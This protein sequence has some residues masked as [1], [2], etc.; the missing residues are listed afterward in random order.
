MSYEAKWSQEE[1]TWPVDHTRGPRIEYGHLGSSLYAPAL[2]SAK[3][4]WKYPRSIGTDDGSFKVCGHRRAVRSGSRLPS[5]LDHTTKF[6]VNRVRAQLAKVAPDSYIPTGVLSALSK[7]TKRQS[8]LV[9]KSHLFGQ[10]IDFGYCSDQVL[11]RPRRCAAYVSGHNGFMLNLVNVE[12]QIYE[13]GGI[14]DLSLEVPTLG[15]ASCSISLSSTIESIKFAC[16]ESTGSSTSLIAARSSRSCQFYRPTATRSE[17]GELLMTL[18]FMTELL[19]DSGQ[20]RDVAFNPWYLRQIGTIN[21]NGTLS[22]YDLKQRGKSIEE[23]FRATLTDKPLNDVKRVKWGSNL[24]QILACDSNYLRGYDLRS[25]EGSH[26]FEYSKRQVSRIRDFHVL[27]KNNLEAV[28]LTSEDIILTDLRMGMKEILSW[29]HYRDPNDFS[30]QSA[31]LSENIEDFHTVIYSTL[32]PVITGYNFGKKDNLAMSLTDPYIFS[33]S[34]GPRVSCIRPETLRFTDDSDTSQLQE[35]EKFITLFHTSVDYSVTQSIYSS[36]EIQ[37]SVINWDSDNLETTAEQKTLGFPEFY[38]SVSK[39]RILDFSGIY[40]YIFDEEDDELMSTISLNKLED[41]FK[42]ISDQAMSNSAQ[43][44]DLQ[45]FTLCDIAPRFGVPS[46]LE[47]FSEKINDVYTLLE[48]NGFI[49]SDLNISSLHWIGG[50]SVE[51]QELYQSLLSIWIRCLPILQEQVA[52]FEVETDHIL[53]RPVSAKVRLRRE[54]IIRKLA[55]CISLES[56]IILKSPKRDQKR[57]EMNT[58][59][60]DSA[61]ASL[62][63]LSRYA[64]FRRPNVDKSSNVNSLALEWHDREDIQHYQW[65]TNSSQ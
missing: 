7:D 37:A 56:K 59:E 8:S 6:S 54:R 11:S 53:V 51:S 12:K 26:S 18:E 30:L 2:S 16:F 52:E 21:S 13:I 5:S 57:T 17:A 64:H 23:V 42:K 4:P 48:D 24:N 19:P 46:D 10:M 36:T 44:S 33:C 31:V 40:N 50:N 45:I 20:I 28:V 61:S 34:S 25:N 1:S 49:V 14:E 47:F 39:E 63:M 43:K 9:Q 3:D 58:L 38:P 15:N 27:S 60:K 32:D 41:V 29:R 62:K 35:H 65:G 55:A 22:I